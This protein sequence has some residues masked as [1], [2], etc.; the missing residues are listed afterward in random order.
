MR[1]SEKFT[2]SKLVPVKVEDGKFGPER[3]LKPHLIH[4]GFE[5]HVQPGAI[6]ITQVTEMGTVYSLK[7]LRNLSD[8]V[9]LNHSRF[10]WMELAFLTQSQALNASPVKSL[11]LVKLIFYHL[12]GLKTV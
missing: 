2:G 12:V 8:F 4:R 6:S 10:T 7:E 11:K 5:H 1:S 3:A 9:N